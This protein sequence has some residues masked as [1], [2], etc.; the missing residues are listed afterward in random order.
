MRMLG[1]NCLGFIN[2]A[3]NVMATFS[4]FASGPTPPGPAAFVTQSGAL[5]TATNSTARRRHFNFGYFIN[6]GN[7]VDV[8]W[9]EAMRAVL[10]DPAIRVGSGYIE[11][12]RNGERFIETARF[13][14]DSGKPL[15]AIK[16]GRTAA[17]ARAAASH[18]GALAG[19]DVVIAA[20][21]EGQG[22]PRVAGRGHL[23]LMR[24]GAVVVDLSITDGG[25]F[26]TTPRTSLREP[27]VVV[28]GVVHI[29][30]PNFAGAVPRTASPAFSFAS[31]SRV[32]MDFEK[33]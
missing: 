1:P 22:A 31:L 9:S 6:T 29:G 23:G 26:E 12:L 7:E 21:R 19:A 20:V 30:V 2:A 3:R 25:A 27:A 11:G 8:E 4:Q 15:V 10:E 24:P 33:I 5:G 16:V 32:L 13:A 17:G 28:D 14:I 18:T